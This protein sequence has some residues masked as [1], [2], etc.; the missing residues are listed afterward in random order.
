MKHLSFVIL[1]ISI[2]LVSCIPQRQFE[3]MK[4]KKEKCEEEKAQLQQENKDLNIKYNDLKSTTEKQEK[5][6]K[7]LSSDTSILNNSL[8]VLNYNYEKLNETYELLLQKNKELLSNST[9]EA[10]KMMDK[11][12]IAEENLQKR[13]EALKNAEKDLEARKQQLEELS[14]KYNASKEELAK[15]E[16]K[17]AEL[18]SILNKKD[19]TVKKL[20]NTVSNALLGFENKGLSVTQKNGKVYVSLEESLLFPSGSITVQERGVEAL[21][22]LAKV[23]ENNPDINVLIEGHTDDVPYKNPSGNIKDNWD[24]SVLRA[25]TIVRILLEN[26]KID[27]KRLS[28]SGRGEYFPIDPAKTKEARAKNRRTEII[29]TPKLDD[30]FKII[31]TN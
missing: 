7:N 31:E 6:I 20:K 30:L 29:L 14:S 19:E 17:L 2:I 1:I 12:Q 18:E 3:D 5:I 10:K 15:K 4:T 23:L 9:S 28:A 8:K 24:L 27:P 11:L 22:K 26:S 21:K 25:T 16:T 13:E